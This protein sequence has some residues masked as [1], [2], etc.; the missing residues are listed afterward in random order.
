MKFCEQGKL[1]IENI[2]E[3]YLLFAQYLGAQEEGFER[4]LTS[5]WTKFFTAFQKQV[6]KSQP[7]EESLEKIKT[8]TKSYKSLDFLIQNS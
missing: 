2:L 6:S 5:N 8:L 7:W 1:L 4:R 3:K